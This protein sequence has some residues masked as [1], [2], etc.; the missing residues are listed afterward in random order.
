MLEVLERREIRRAASQIS[1]E[2]GLSY[3]ASD[4]GVC[5]DGTFRRRI[6]LS[7]GRFAIVEN[8]REFSIVPWRPELVRARGKDAATIIPRER[9]AWELGRHRGL[10][11]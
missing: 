11:I 3:V 10:D 6:D 4:D 8:G 9:I 7:S 2:T 1:N 5:A